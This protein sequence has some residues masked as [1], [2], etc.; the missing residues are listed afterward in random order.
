MRF[1]EQPYRI[2]EPSEWAC[3]IDSNYAQSL[4]REIDRDSIELLKNDAGILPI[5][6]DQKVAVIGP[7]AAG[8]VNY[9]DYVVYRSQYRGVQ[10]LTGIENAVGDV[11]Y[12]Q[13]CER[14]SLD[15]SV[16]PEA[17][18]AEEE[19]DVA[20]VIVGTWSHDQ[21]E[22]REGLNATTGEHVDVTLLTS[23]VPCALSF[24]RSSTLRLC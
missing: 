22:L 5:S 1:F 15:Q 2:P 23:S 9:G 13:G 18:A 17:I 8:Y 19:A 3:Y 20:I 4:A 24:R 6:K 21:N 14:W 16:F 11:T 12:A 7:M 10:Y